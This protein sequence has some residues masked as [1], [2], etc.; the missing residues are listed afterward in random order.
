LVTSGVGTSSEQS[1]GQHE[2]FAAAEPVTVVLGADQVRD[3]VVGEVFP[4]LRKHFFEIGVEFGPGRLDGGPVAGDVPVE[5]FLDL[6]G[7]CGEQLPVLTRCAEQRA[8]DRGGVPARDIGDHVAV[9]D[10]GQR[11]D[12][13]SDDVD[14]ERP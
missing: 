12:E 3:Q 14:D 7:P 13:F 4:A 6:I 5:Y 10:G 1:G 9:S 11:V 8:D 2:K